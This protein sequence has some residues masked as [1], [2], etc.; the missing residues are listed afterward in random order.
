MRGFR[1][2]STVAGAGRIA[3]KLRAVVVVVVAAA[4]AVAVAVSWHA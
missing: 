2:T 1:S 3:P 4:A